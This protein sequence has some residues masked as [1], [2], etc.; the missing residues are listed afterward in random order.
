MSSNHQTPQPAPRALCAAFA[1]LLPLLSLDMLDQEEA[2]AVAAHVR[3]CDYCQREV[4]SYGALRDAILR[5]DAR[6][7][8]E[9]VL[10]LLTLAAVRDVA[11]RE[12]AEPLVFR[13]PA[14]WQAPPISQTLRQRFRLMGAIE[15]LAAVL[16][17]ALLG[18]LL[19]SRQHASSGAVAPTLDKTSQAYLDM[20]RTNYVPLAQANTTAQFCV[21]S[22]GLTVLAADRLGMMQTCRAPLAS[23]LLTAHHLSD[24]LAHA[25][26]PAP[27]RALNAALRRGTERLIP[28][29]V[30][31]L[32]AIDA[33]NVA[34]FLGTEDPASAAIIAFQEPINQINAQIHAG[35]P[36]APAPLQ[37]MVWD[38]D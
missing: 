21:G 3:T 22:V 20:L 15:A 28:V 7:A 18:G 31:Q 30:T 11:D 35:P 29:L 6:D 19:V 8:E 23:E 2:A 16:I 1:P 26:P 13:A 32:A 37:Q 5:E 17:I 38:F 9:H 27:W 33:Q 4:A 34:Q 14:S 36:P 24:Q 12:E 25:A 10:P